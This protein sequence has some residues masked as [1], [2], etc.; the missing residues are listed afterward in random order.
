[1]RNL[2]PFLTL[3][4]AGV[5]HCESSEGKSPQQEALTKYLSAL[6]SMPTETTHLE[7]NNKALRWVEDQLSPLRLNFKHQIFE[8]HPTLVITTQETKTPDLFLVS[9]IDVVPAPNSLY[10]PR[11]VGNKMYGRGVYDMK[12]AIACYILL[13]H[14]LKDH[15]KDINIGLML[16][17]DEEMGGMQGVKRL[18]E[19]GYSSKIAFLPDG[20]FDWNFEESAKGV[21]Q[22]KITAQGVSSHGSR[23][24]LGENAIDILTA[25]LRD[26]QA[27]FEQE[28]LRYDTYF[29]TANVGII[30][31]GKSVNQVPDYAEAKIDIRYPPNIQGAD[32]YSAL[33]KL[34][35][36]DPRL[37]IEITAEGAPH[38]VDLHHPSFVKFRD[39]AQQIYGQ[40]VGKMLAHGASDARFFGERH[41]PVLVIAPKGGE[42][43]SEGE[44]IDLEDLTR[45]YHVLKQW[46]LETTLPADSNT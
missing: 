45:F 26:V 17:S 27:Y 23:P 4:I 28:K 19:T 46:V 40:K 15:L 38:H 32:I 20:G 41:I 9:H 31:G 30:Q 2:L 33:K 5:M 29:P 24:W 7:E 14:E 25:A 36:K 10:H 1:M 42:I 37:S 43:H 39:I 44:W 16:T 12:M 35:Q 13:L 6:V 21:L 22:V 3:F 8:G 18:L 34:L 11:I